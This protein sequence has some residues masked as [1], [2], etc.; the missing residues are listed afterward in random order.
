MEKAEFNIKKYR[1]IKKKVY[2]WQDLAATASKH[3]V[4]G[5]Q[6]RSSIFKCFR[7]NTQKAQTAFLD[8][9]ELGKPYANYFFKIYNSL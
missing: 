9:K 8:T 2:R 3:F 4:D 7:D 1:P 5:E 6:K